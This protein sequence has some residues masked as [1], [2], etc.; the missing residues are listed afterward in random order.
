MCMFHLCVAEQ[1]LAGT[2]ECGM[3]VLGW[4]GLWGTLVMAI[5]GMPLAWFLPGTDIG[6]SPLHRL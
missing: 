1:D 6:G 3:Q 4:E 2:S 5:I